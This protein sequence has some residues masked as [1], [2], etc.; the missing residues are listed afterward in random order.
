[1]C[2]LAGTEVHVARK[3]NANFISPSNSADTQLVD[4]NFTFMLTKGRGVQGP[5]VLLMEN[6]NTA[7]ETQKF[8][9]VL[10]NLITTIRVQNDLGLVHCTVQPKISSLVNSIFTYVGLGIAVVGVP[11][12]VALGPVAG[13][14]YA[15]G[16]LAAA[17]AGTAWSFLTPDTKSYPAMPLGA[18]LDASVIIGSFDVFVTRIT[19]DGTALAVQSAL[20]ADKSGNFRLSSIASNDWKDIVRLDSLIAT[21]STL[22]TRG[23]LPLKG[24][25]AIPSG[26]N[27]INTNA[28]VNRG[29]YS[30]PKVG[31][32]RTALYHDQIRTQD[33]AEINLFRKDLNSFVAVCYES[34]GRSDLGCKIAQLPTAG[35]FALLLYSYT[36]TGCSAGDIDEIRADDVSGMLYAINHDAQKRQAYFSTDD[37]KFMAVRPTASSW[38]VQYKYPRDETR[39]VFLRVT[40]SPVINTII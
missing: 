10:T 18:E 19:Q 7:Q 9:V 37:N 30:Y 31:Q 34:V 36:I 28:N 8:E 13:T 26:C 3:L 15:L 39:I 38:T 24:L 16:G 33:E 29:I 25:S 17:M 12:A 1:M 14:A 5:Q 32:S 20:M 2:V 21:G 11:V 22:N 40:E 23:F 35:Q 6:P 4:G 27:V